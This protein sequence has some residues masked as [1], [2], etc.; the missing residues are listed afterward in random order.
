M[1]TLYKESNTEEEFNKKHIKRDH[2]K[3]TPHLCLLARITFL[4]CPVTLTIKLVFKSACFQVWG[5]NYF[6]S[7]FHIGLRPIKHNYQSFLNKNQT[8]YYSFGSW[9]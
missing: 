6:P 1:I 5:T 7:L 4:L 3:K 8:C 2:S 9:L